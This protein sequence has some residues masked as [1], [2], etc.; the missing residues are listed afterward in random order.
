MMK[1]TILFLIIT[2][3]FLYAGDGDKVETSAECLDCHEEVK[4]ILVKTV[5][6]QTFKVTC[7]DCH[8]TGVKTHIDDPDLGNIATGKGLQGQQDCLSCHESTIHRRTPGANIHM[9]AQVECADCHAMHREGVRTSTPLLAAH[10]QRELCGSCHTD[11]MA[12]LRKPYGHKLTHGGMTCA[13]CHD[14]HGGSGEMRFTKGSLNETCVS[15]HNNLRGPFVFAHV[16]GHNGD[17]MSCHEAHGSSN[18]RQLTRTNT[19]QLCIECHSSVGT[20]PLGSIPPSFHDPR[21]PR[22]KE[23]AVCHTAVHGSSRSPDLL[24]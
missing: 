6:T 24:K 11:V 20:A 22:F 15:C 16:S 10:S 19:Y 4:D 8:S 2:G 5:H 12:T 9:S 18:P 23:C 17:C 3:L 14:A 7:V 1:H 13:S 21:S